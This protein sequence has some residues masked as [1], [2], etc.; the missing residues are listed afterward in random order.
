[1][2]C[3]ETQLELLLEWFDDLTTYS[4]NMDLKVEIISHDDQIDT[5]MNSY[6]NRVRHLQ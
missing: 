2:N 6:D 1:M 5:Y 4:N 3:F